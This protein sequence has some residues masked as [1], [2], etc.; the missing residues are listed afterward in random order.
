MK[1][2]LSITLLIIAAFFLFLFLIGGFIYYQFTSEP[3]VP[4]QVFLTV[5]LNST[6]VE[7]ETS[8]LEKSL[9]LHDLWLHIRRAERDSR[10]QGLLVNIEDLGGNSAEFEEIGSFLSHYK[11]E[12]GKPVIAFMIN[13]GL[14]DLYLASYA[15]KVFTFKGSDLFISGLAGQ[16]TF[17]KKTLDL[18][19]I[20][21]E[22]LHV[23]AYK[24]A[25]NMYTHSEMTPEHRESF[26]QFFGD[27]HRTMVAQIA[28]NRK[29]SEDKVETIVQDSPFGNESYLKA[30]LLDGICYPDE[31]LKLAGFADAATFPIETYMQTTSPKAFSG[32]DTV[33][34][35]F[36]EGEINMG[37]SGKGG[38]F[39]DKVLGAETVAAQLSRLR[40]NPRVKAVVMR[41]NSPG[42]SAVAS[43]LIYREA[44]LLAKEK[45][46]VIS[47]GGMAASGGYWIS[48]P[49]RHIVC[50][51]LT[52]T[53]SIGVLFGKFNLK[54]FYDKIGI[55]KETV[56]TSTYAD[57]FSDYRNF[58]PEERERITQMML[59]LYQQF[60]GKVAASRKMS[61]QEVDQV[62]QGRI[63][64]GSRALE[65]K[66]VDELGG[67][68]QAL[69]SA[70][71][72]AGL[73]PEQMTVATFPAKK[74]LLDMI[75]EMVGDQGLAVNSEIQTIQK[76]I[77]SC[78]STFFPA[79]RMAYKVE[80]E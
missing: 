59:R 66:L 63:W 1:R 38:L 79:Y 30:G 44:E 5:N 49:A 27:L 54:G 34:V 11:A 73:K 61:T 18:L 20:E 36:A 80:T 42:G 9:T 33:A 77:S 48:M 6:M 25:G 28:K 8:P 51:R 14:R 67:L 78:R 23:G 57:I 13:G 17:I 32:K 50:D 29:I 68:W 10:I 43:D 47:M 40:K 55:T 56:K 24:T 71:K 74:G 35:L 69:D 3:S 52:V 70:A 60:I 16:A 21:S 76:R 12:T 15:D 45:P 19:G 58:S 75:L 7:H 31:V 22:F 53:G 37:P 64:S 62:A 2:G 41:V 72:L 26:S 39:G 65:L 4:D 46:L